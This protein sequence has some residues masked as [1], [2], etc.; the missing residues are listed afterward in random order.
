[1]GAFGEWLDLVNFER[2]WIRD[3]A[4]FWRNDLLSEM[5]SFS[6]EK[7]TRFF[8]CDSLLSMS[9]LPEKS[10]IEIDLSSVVDY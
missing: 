2:R 5:T 1:M 9:F 7:E 6:V 8:F 3:C 4:N 10:S